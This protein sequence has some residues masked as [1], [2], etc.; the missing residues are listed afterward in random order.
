MNQL[1]LQLWACWSSSNADFYRLH[2]ANHQ[3]SL[4]LQACWL[5][6]NTSSVC[7]L[8]HVSY[9]AASACLLMLS[10]LDSIFFDL[11]FLTHFSIIFLFSWSYSHVWDFDQIYCCKQL[12][13][14]MS[15]FCQEIFCLLCF[16]LCFVSL[17]EIPVKSISTSC[18]LILCSISEKDLV[19]TFKFQYR[20]TNFSNICILWMI[21]NFANLINRDLI[22]SF[23]KF[24]WR[25]CLT[26]LSAHCL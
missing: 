17:F 6:W 23:I 4:Q 2:W 13:C 7:L 10:F 11:N 5:S 9:S 26:C 16:S 3:F 18:Y 19:F 24:K 8:E 21:V 14:L 25:H 12:F 22:R 20:S 1:C 15:C